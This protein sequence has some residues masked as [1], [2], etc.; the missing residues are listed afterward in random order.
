MPTFANR[1]SLSSVRAKINTLS[2]RVGPLDRAYRRAVVGI[3][4]AMLGEALVGA[5]P[6]Y[7]MVMWAIRVD[8]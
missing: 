2:G 1:E 5:L 8:R 6:G 3:A 7:V 4:H